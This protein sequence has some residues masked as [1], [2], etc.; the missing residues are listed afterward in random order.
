MLARVLYYLLLSF[1]ADFL[2]ERTQA[3]AMA[4]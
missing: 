1:K 4:G 3:R 2:N